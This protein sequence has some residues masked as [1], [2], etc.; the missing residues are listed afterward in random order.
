M[1]D[2]DLLL[3]KQKLE[4]TMAVTMKRDAWVP[5][6]GGTETPFLACGKRILYV[7]NPKQ[8]KHA[9]LDLGSDMVMTDDEYFALIAPLSAGR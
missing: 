1:N 8:H 2:L 9:F 4:Y 5:A 7:Y 6:C 3:Q